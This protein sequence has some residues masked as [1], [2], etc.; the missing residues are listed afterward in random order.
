MKIV[1]GAE[2][3]VL[4]DPHKVK[5]IF[6]AMLKDRPI[7]KRI[8]ELMCVSQPLRFADA[9]I[10]AIESAPAFEVLAIAIAERCGITIIEAWGLKR[11][12]P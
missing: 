10:C 6:V 8:A 7:L 9:P 5:D 3:R 2:H 11:T 4:A 12:E 1:H